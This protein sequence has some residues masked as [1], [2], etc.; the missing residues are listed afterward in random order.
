MMIL[1]ISSQSWVKKERLNNHYN[2]FLIKM[3]KNLSCLADLINLTEQVDLIFHK[4]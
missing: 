3:I 2:E 1:N 4:N